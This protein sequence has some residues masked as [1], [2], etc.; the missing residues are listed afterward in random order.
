MRTY[1]PDLFVQNPYAGKLPAV[2]GSETSEAAA[3]D[4]AGGAKS[5]R[6]MI[7]EFLTR[8]GGATDDEIEEMFT[9]RHQTAS[10]RRRELVLRG[11]VRDSGHQKPTRSGSNATIWEVVP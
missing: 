9:L 3:E 10:A 8:V 1:L 4:A 2:K 11:L 7:Y 6:R 5:I